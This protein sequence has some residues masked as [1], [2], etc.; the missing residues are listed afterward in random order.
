MIE[1]ALYGGAQRAGMMGPRGGGLREVSE[2]RH[3]NCPR[4]PA[5][6]TPEPRGNLRITNI[7]NIRASVL[8]GGCRNLAPDLRAPKTALKN[9]MEDFSRPEEGAKR[10]LSEPLV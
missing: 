9:P 1:A 3:R 7:S 6:G 5:L 8:R 2:A 4:L 10:G